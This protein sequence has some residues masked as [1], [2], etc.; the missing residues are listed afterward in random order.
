MVFGLEDDDNGFVELVDCRHI[1]KA[2]KLDL[3]VEYEGRKRM[4]HLI[5]Y[6]WFVQH[7]HI[8]MFEYV[9]LKSL[10]TPPLGWEFS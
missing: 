3:F 5:I 1:F 2:S 8:L 10:D 4:N 6:I 9:K 7:I